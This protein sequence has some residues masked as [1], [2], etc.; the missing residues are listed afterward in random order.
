[1]LRWRL[2]SG[3]GLAGWLL[4]ARGEL[5]RQ[6]Q[7]GAAGCDACGVGKEAPAGLIDGRGCAI[8]GISLSHWLYLLVWVRAGRGVASTAPACYISTIIPN[9]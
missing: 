5:C 9:W 7:D 8:L 3:Q 4:L 2:G 6:R 1:V